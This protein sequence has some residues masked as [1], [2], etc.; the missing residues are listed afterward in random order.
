MGAPAEEATYRGTPGWMDW[1]D[2]EEP[3]SVLKY[4]R[5]S[6]EHYS[7]EMRSIVQAMMAV[8]P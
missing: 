5:R 8:S 3:Q 1:Y 6:Y 2:T 4:Q 7:D